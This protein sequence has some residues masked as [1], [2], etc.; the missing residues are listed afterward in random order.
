M[1]PEILAI[2][3]AAEQ[4][5]NDGKN[6][7]A[8]A[9]NIEILALDENFVRAHLA[10]SVLYHKIEAHDKSVAHAEKAY[11]LEPD[12]FNAAAL[13]VTYQRAFEGTKD[14]VYIQ[15]AESVNTNMR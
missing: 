13:S 6:E 15:K 2:E 7:E 3:K 4:L 9:K 5:K 12:D 1:T 14:P 11:Q 10:L 8:I